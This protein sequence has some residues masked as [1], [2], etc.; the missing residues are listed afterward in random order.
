MIHEASVR[1]HSRGANNGHTYYM[2]ESKESLK[3]LKE[4]RQIQLNKRH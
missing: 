1:K 2:V 4:F 3:A